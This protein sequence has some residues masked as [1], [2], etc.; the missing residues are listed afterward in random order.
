MQR[1]SNEEDHPGLIDAF[2]CALSSQKQ[3]QFFAFF[4]SKHRS[5]IVL[6]CLPLKNVCINRLAAS[7]E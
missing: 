3:R 7:V 6:A 4:C 1:F 2:T 5:H